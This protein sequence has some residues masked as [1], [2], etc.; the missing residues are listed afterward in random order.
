MSSSAAGSPPPSGGARPRRPTGWVNT[1]ARGPFRARAPR[2]LRYHASVP[3]YAGAR[4]LGVMNLAMRGWRRL[5]RQEL[6]LL[7]TVADQ[8]SVAIERERLREQAIAA[9]R[10]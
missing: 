10:A 7:T 6:D 3:L 8:I 1:H 5:T 4:P 2:G 9:P